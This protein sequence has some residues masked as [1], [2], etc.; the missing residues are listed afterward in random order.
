MYIPIW[1]VVIALVLFFIYRSKNKVGVS[2]EG[3]E[4]AVGVLKESIFNLEHFDSPHFVDVQ[5]AFDAMEVNY[6][7]LKERFASIPEKAIEVARDW[8][9]YVEALR[10]LKYARVMLDV[11]WSDNASENA[12]ENF[13]EPSIIKEEIEKKFK[14]LLKK[15]FQNIPPDYFQRIKNMKKFEKKAKKIYGE[16]DEWKYYYNDSG[17][18]FRLEEKRRK[19]K[20][21]GKRI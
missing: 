11:D 7:R 6:F 15:D 9:R 19:E 16:F 21:S 1:L 5:D 13:R 10:D 4:G 2:T 8:Y 12:K 14:S 18:F 3:I 17:N 20:K